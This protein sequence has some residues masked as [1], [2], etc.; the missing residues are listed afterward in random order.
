MKSLW[1][2][3]SI[4]L[5]ASCTV[6][7]DRFQQYQNGDMSG[8][9]VIEYEDAGGFDLETFYKSYSFTPNPDDNILE[10]KNYFRTVAMHLASQKQKNIER[11]L[12]SQIN[13]NSGRNILD[14]NYAIYVSGFVKY[15]E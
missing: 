7:P 3:L 10:A 6:V 13:V 5:L 11:I 2:V 9:Y 1:S 12:S 14:G 4:L 8:G 15:K